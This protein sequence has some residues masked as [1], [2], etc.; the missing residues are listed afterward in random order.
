MVVKDGDQ[1]VADSLYNVNTLTG[2]ITFDASLVGK[3]VT[4]TLTPRYAAS[5]NVKTFKLVLNNGVNVYTNTELKSRYSDLSVH[6]INILRNITAELNADDYM[7]GHG[8]NIENVTLSSTTLEGV[9]TGTPQNDYSHGVYNRLTTDTSDTMKINGNFFAI[10]GSKLP[11]IDNRYD[12]YGASGSKF[13]TGDSYRIANV[14]IG[15]FLY[16]NCTLDNDGTTLARYQGGTLTMDNLLVSGNNV[17]SLSDAS[18]DL[19]DGKVPLLKMSA[20]YLGIVCRGGT[21]NLD[22]VHVKN[23]SIGIF[24]DGGIDG[25]TGND[26]IAFNS[27]KHAVVINMD[28]CRVTESWANDVYGYYLTKFTI[29]NTVLSATSGG[30]AIALD[31]KPASKATNDLQIEVNIDYYTAA[32]IQNWVTGLEAWFVAYGH[33]S[34]AL[35]VKTTINDSVSG[36]GLTDLDSTSQMMNFAIFARSGGNYENSEWDADPQGAPSVKINVTNIPAALIMY[37]MHDTVA[38]MAQGYGISEEMAATQISN[39]MASNGIFC[40]AEGQNA[41]MYLVYSM[42]SRN[43]VMTVG[44]PLYIQGTQPR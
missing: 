21:V 31:D 36:N 41:Q 15:I 26:E 4:I 39:Q 13:T 18:Q 11:Y 40:W 8:K 34:T 22:N 20:A 9:D 30:A 38:A 25:Y 44:I 33:S 2:A 10:D 12:Q 6:Q 23:T 28:N 7:A 29:N 37:A 19:G 43:S 17:M 27:D 16:R 5:T 14:Q 3:T 24:T 42:G 35:G 1:V 32:N